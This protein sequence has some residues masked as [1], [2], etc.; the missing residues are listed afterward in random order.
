MNNYKSALKFIRIILMIIVIFFLPSTIDG[1]PNERTKF[2]ISIVFFSIIFILLLY[3]SYKDFINKQYSTTIF[4]I[5]SDVVII[6][7]YIVFAV[8]FFKYYKHILSSG[9]KLNIN[10]IFLLPWTVILLR[11]FLKSDRFIKKRN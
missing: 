9:I 1:I 11:H 5:L 2:I 3:E 6:F 8:I 10:Q 7:L 4:I